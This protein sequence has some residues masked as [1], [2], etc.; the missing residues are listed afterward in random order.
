[1]RIKRSKINIKRFTTSLVRKTAQ[2][3]FYRQLRLEQRANVRGREHQQGKSNHKVTL[4]AAAFPPDLESIEMSYPL[5]DLQ[6]GNNAMCIIYRCLEPQVLGFAKFSPVLE[7]V[8]RI[9]E[10]M[11]LHL[12][13]LRRK[14]HSLPDILR[15]IYLRISL[16]LYPVSLPLQ[17]LVIAAFPPYSPSLCRGV[18]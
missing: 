2:A 14:A 3:V 4:W 16:S 11:G 18:R 12:Q 8:F 9:R 7:E 5:F 17:V 15:V 6:C 13:Q 1:M 10:P